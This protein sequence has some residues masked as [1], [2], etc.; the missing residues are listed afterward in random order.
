MTPLDRFQINCTGQN[1]RPLTVSSVK[2]SVS[3]I[4]VA[5]SRMA[6]LGRKEP[7]SNSLRHRLLIVTLLTFDHYKATTRHF[8]EIDDL[9]I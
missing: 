8:R 4:D 9:M 2:R 6:A 1:E 3:Q 7:V 5:D